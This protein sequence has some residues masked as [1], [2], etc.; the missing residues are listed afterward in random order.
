MADRGP[1]MDTSRMKAAQR[2]RRKKETGTMLLSEVQEDVSCH[3]DEILRCFKPGAKIAVLV[4]SPGYP[5]R[6][7][8][9]TNDD[10]D[11]LTAMI[12]RRKSMGASH[13]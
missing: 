2:K 8:V 6:D 4:R 5:H 10:L 1:I 12:A 3:M 11:E 9:M 7:F 13:G